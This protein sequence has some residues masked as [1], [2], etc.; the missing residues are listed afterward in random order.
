MVRAF[1]ETDEAADIGIF[2]V[3]V[4]SRLAA[5]ATGLRR[6]WRT[7]RVPDADAVMIVSLNTCNREGVAAGQPWFMFD[8]LEAERDRLAA[9]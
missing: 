9:L 1:R 7:D 5:R 8:G 4:I 2:V 6:E 3:T